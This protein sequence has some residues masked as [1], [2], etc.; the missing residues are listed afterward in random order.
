M[1]LKKGILLKKIRN[2]SQP[3]T[4]QQNK[5]LPQRFMITWLS[6]LQIRKD[7]RKLLMQLEIT[8]CLRD[9]PKSYVQGYD[10]YANINPALK[11]DTALDL[12]RI[13]VNIW[14]IFT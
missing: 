11:T 3:L 5:N 12:S 1:D 4:L 7:L 8:S 10:A 14:V 9:G 13:N 6:Y 2:N